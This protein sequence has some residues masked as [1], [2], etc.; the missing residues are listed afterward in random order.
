M[1]TKCTCVYKHKH[2]CTSIHNMHKFHQIS[3]LYISFKN[4]IY[5]P[6]ISFGKYSIVYLKGHFF[7]H[8]IPLCKCFIEC[9]LLKDI[10]VSSKL[11]LSPKKK[12]CNDLTCSICNYFHTW[13][14]RWD[15]FLG[16]KLKGQHKSI[17]L[18]IVL[19]LH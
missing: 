4:S 14:Y 2:T 8:C 15:G 13:T 5:A 18:F 1:C 6:T 10:F 7:M 3:I 9:F 19:M 17:Y 11:F 12:A 16:V